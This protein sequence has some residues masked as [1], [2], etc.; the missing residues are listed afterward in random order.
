MARSK[1]SHLWLKEHFQDPYVK[2]AQKQGLRSRAA[3]KLLEINDKDRLIR[4]G[5]LVVDL[6]A[7][8]GGWSQIVGQLLKGQGQIIAM[9]LLP[10]TDLPHVTFIQGDFRD[11]AMLALLQKNVNH[12]LVDLVLSDMAPNMSG[13]EAVD[14]AKVMYLAECAWHFA[15]ECLKPGGDLL[16]KVFQGRGFDE[17]LQTLRQSFSK[18]LI[19][20]PKASRARSAEVYLLARGKKPVT[21]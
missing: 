15:V 8:P 7:A 11:E 10:M 14:Q 20:K 6:G 2:M 3:F 18:V 5:M 21:L 9:D 13:M 17:Y 19:R 12:R 1:S 4:P 16:V